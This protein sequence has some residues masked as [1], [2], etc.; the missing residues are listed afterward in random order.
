MLILTHR[1]ARRRGAADNDDD[2]CVYFDPAY[3]WRLFSSPTCTCTHEQPQA[4]TARA[5]SQHRTPQHEGETDAKERACRAARQ[6]CIISFTPTPPAPPKRLVACPRLCPPRNTLAPAWS[7]AAN[8]GHWL[9]GGRSSWC[10]ELENRS[11]GPAKGMAC[12]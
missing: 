12:G 6:R 8:M 3:T 9:V 1:F 4:T 11:A 7:K 2:Q 5:G 10:L